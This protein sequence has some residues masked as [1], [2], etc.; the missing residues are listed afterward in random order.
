MPSLVDIGSVVLEKMKSRQ[1]DRQMEGRVDSE[2]HVIR[3]AHLSFQLYLFILQE[4]LIL[5]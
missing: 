2:Y 1:T 5:I 3:K 4:H